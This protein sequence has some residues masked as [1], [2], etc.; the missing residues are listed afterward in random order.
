MT[1]PARYPCLSGIASL[2]FRLI[3]IHHVP[4]IP[5]EVYRRWAVLFLQ[6]LLTAFRTYRQAV[7]RE[8]LEVLEMPQALVAM[9]D[10]NGHQAAFL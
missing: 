7:V 6:R 4:P 2:L 1:F 5:L 8:V 10:V 9:V 3:L